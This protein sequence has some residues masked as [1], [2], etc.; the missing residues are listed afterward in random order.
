MFW[1]AIFVLSLCSLGLG[2]ITDVRVLL[3]HSNAQSSEA[4]ATSN[5]GE[6]SARGVVAGETGLIASEDQSLITFA[7]AGGRTLTMPEPLS[8]TRA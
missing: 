3:T 6:H 2:S 4:R 8:M 1:G 5:S 7:Q